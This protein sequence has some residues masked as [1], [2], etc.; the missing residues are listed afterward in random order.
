[1]GMVYGE[2]AAQLVL[3]SRE[4]AER[5]GA[6]PLARIAGF[7]T[8]SESS[9]ISNLPTGDSIRRAIRAALVSA[10]MLPAAI[11]YVNAHGNSTRED[12]AAEAQA[13]RDTLGNVPVTAP[14]SFFGNLNQ[15]TGMVELAISL[16]A[17]EK[18]I[19][20]PTLN[21]K[22]PDSECPVNVVTELQPATRPAFMKL[23]HTATGQAAAVVVAAVS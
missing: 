11:G 4:H 7:A 2:G 17:M 1:M 19:V 23:N 12:D 8:R 13:I 20:P 3:E 14:K 15:G 5:R 21:Y 16:L 22:T 10:E 9:A 18:S 6:R